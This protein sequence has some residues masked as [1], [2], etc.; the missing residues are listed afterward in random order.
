MPLTASRSES[1]TCEA[2]SWYRHRMPR[3]FLMSEHKGLA[4]CVDDPGIGVQIWR[5]IFLSQ[6]G[7][8]LDASAPTFS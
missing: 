8:L 3:V 6:A 7:S 4:W 5:S 1:L 2:R